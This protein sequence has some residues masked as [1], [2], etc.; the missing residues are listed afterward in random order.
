NGLPR[1]VLNYQLKS[2]AI[3]TD[4]QLLAQHLEENSQAVGEMCHVFF[5]LFFKQ[6]DVTFTYKKDCK[7]VEFTNF[8]LYLQTLLT[9]SVG[10]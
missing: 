2:Y 10:I 8:Q 9:F 1:G 7:N 5:V 3:E 4:S 6:E